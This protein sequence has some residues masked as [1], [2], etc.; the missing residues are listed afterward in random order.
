M[1]F[2]G[3]EDLAN[4]IDDPDLD[5]TPQDIMVLKGAGPRRPPACRKPATCPSRRS[6]RGPG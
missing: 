1:V 6:S 5:V 4:R 2:D 3:L